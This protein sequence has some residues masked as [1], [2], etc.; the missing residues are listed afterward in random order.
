MRGNIAAPLACLRL[1][2]LTYVVNFVE[3]IPL[4]LLDTIFRR[5]KGPL[6]A[7]RK[8]YKL[9]VTNA[10]SKR[11]YRDFGVP[12]S[13]DGR[14]EMIVLHVILIVLRLRGEGRGADLFVQDLIETLIDDMDR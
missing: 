10:R 2:R 13:V 3:E 14:F 11:F 6:E 8:A 9:A 4:P 1:A 12:D 5:D 7:A